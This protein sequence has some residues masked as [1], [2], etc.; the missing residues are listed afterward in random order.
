VAVELAEELG[1]DRRLLYAALLK[2]VRAN[3]DKIATLPITFGQDATILISEGAK[4]APEDGS[5]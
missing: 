5:G 4:T 1:I 3:L 2:L